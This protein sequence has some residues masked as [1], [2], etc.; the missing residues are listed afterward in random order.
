MGRRDGWQRAAVVAVVALAAVTGVAVVRRDLPRP[1]PRP[2]PPATRAREPAEEPVARST[3]PPASLPEGAGP[4]RSPRWTAKNAADRW[5]GP[6]EVH[7]PVVVGGLVVAVGG[8]PGLDRVG[9]YDA[10]TGRPR[11]RHQIGGVASLWAASRRTAVVGS[12]RGELEA[13]APETG[14]RRWRV[15]LA[16]GQGPDGATISGDRLVVATSFPGEGDL[17]PP[18]VY[19][20]DARTGRRRWRAV[21][22]RGTDLQW[23]GPVL[24]K[25]LLL[26]ASTPSHPG[27]APGHALHALDEATGRAR[28]DLALPGSEPG[29]HTERPLLHRGLIVVPAAGALLAVDP[30]S[31]RPVWSRPGQG[32]PMV[33]GTT[34]GLVLTAFQDGLVALSVGDGQERWRLPL[35]GDEFQWVGPTGGRIM[36]HDGTVYA[37]T[38]GL[39]L[40]LDPTTGTERWRSLTGPA[41][42]PP[43]RVAD[44][45]YVATTEGLVALE[46]ASG[47]IA[48]VGD[49]HRLAGGPVAAAGR[50]L[51]TTRSGD[52][53]GYAP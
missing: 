42:G 36:L 29:F 22:R 25:G 41:V 19:A 46:A 28:W 20:L 47:R 33:A 5:E 4:A 24:A 11:W 17:R 8:R 9:A 10:R 3:V 7:G 30:G 2:A 35:P 39:A 38:A 44:R 21:L 50:V 16:P 18:V 52:L 45:V 13:L 53:L 1:D 27:S 23:A 26:V 15:R 6:P 49:R 14:R 31:G 43:L 37:L 12:E 34:G 48:W 40:A 51:V 32:L